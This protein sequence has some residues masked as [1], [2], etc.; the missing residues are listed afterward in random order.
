MPLDIDDKKPLFRRPRRVHSVKR[1]KMFRGRLNIINE[2]LVFSA[3]KCIVFERDFL[4]LPHNNMVWPPYLTSLTL[5]GQWNVTWTLPHTLLHL[6]FD[7]D[8]DPRKQLFSNDMLPPSLTSLSFGYLFDRR[9][10]A[11]S[12]PSSLTF[13]RLGYW[14]DHPLPQYGLRRR[15]HF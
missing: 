6:S 13:L 15:R 9:I 7:E 4:L 1:V 12:L 2:W 3:I 5:A 8:F 14:F 11:H 10:D